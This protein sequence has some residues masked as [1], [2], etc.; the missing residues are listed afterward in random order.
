MASKKN[1]KNPKNTPIKQSEE[2]FN[3]HATWRVFKIMSEF[4]DAFEELKDIG[5]AVTVWGSAN[6][7]SPYID[8][9]Q[10][11][12]KAISQAGFSVITGGGPGVMEAANK[13]AK[14]GK[15]KSIGLN[16]HIP[17][18]QVANPYL[19]LCIEFKYFFVR[20][21]MFVKHSLAFVIMPGG[22]GT[23]DELFECLTLI[24]TK[25][26]PPFPVILVGKDYWQGLIDWFKKSVVP[27]GHISLKDLELLTITDD[28]KT[29]VKMIKKG[30]PMS[31]FNS[32]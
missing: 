25:K 17:N 16:I 30:S 8:L 32:F 7:Q 1:K 4:V 26:S 10:K 19:D 11:T 27:T 23:I 3:A 18:E 28:P 31:N 29:V 21:V 9:A 6:P 22:F 5:P 2:E 24:Q 13:G 20:K 12:A 15:G 14:E